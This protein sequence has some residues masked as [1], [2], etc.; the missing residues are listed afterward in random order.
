MEDIYE[1][2]LELCKDYIDDYKKC[3]EIDDRKNLNES[4]IHNLVYYTFNIEFNDFEDLI[5]SLI[6][7]A[8]LGKS[9]LTEKIYQGFGVNDH[10][11][12]K[13]EYVISS[14]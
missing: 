5:N 6:P 14:I 2:A 7:L 13:K 12:I 10:W 3:N 11:L 8:M 9:P 1:L 4:D